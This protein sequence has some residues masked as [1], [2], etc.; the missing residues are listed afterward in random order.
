MKPGWKTTEFWLVVVHN[1]IYIVGGLKG[2]ISPKIATI[3]TI[4]LTA[5]YSILRTTLKM[6]SD[7]ISNS[8]DP[9]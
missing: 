2:V 1:L 4:A 8:S 9:T 6:T 5:V 3:A 7:G